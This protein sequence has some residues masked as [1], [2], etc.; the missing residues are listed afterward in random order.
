[1]QDI[2]DACEE[3]SKCFLK[4]VLY[5]TSLGEGGPHEVGYVVACDC[6][7]YD[8]DSLAA[9]ALAETL[10][11]D[12][13]AG[14]WGEGH[15]ILDSTGTPLTIGRALDALGEAAAARSGVSESP[16]SSSKSSSSS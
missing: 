5:P 10:G 11:E 14:A 7:E 9:D 13:T 16:S 8:A 1:M 3:C 6:L 2:Y 12:F 15:V 4:G